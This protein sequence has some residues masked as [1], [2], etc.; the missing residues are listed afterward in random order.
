MRTIPREVQSFANIKASFNLSNTQK[1]VLIGTLL[2][3]ASL[4]KR[5]NY[6]RLHIKH[7]K[8]QLPLVKYKHTIF[9][10][11]TNMPIRVFTQKVGIKIYDSCEFVTLTHSVFS[12]FHQI[13]YPDNKKRITLDILEQFTNPL[14]LAV[15]YM[16]DGSAEYAGLAFNTQCFTKTELAL[17]QK[18]LKSHFDLKTTIRK[19]K[20]GWIVYIPKKEVAYF[21]QLVQPYI[22]PEFK[23][24]LIPYSMRV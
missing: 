13:M 24:K 5:G 21:K 11:I 8:K 10:N 6:H 1:A 18:H 19:N 7:S 12:K 2:G 15:L 20:K 16:D 22:L 3:D 4:Q 23:Y 14:G 17:F 9:S